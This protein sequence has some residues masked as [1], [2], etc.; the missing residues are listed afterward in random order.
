MHY[1]ADQFDA[2]S[3]LDT[4][5]KGREIL[6]NQYTVFDYD[7]SQPLEYF[8]VTRNNEASS[9]VSISVSNP[10]LLATRK[11]FLRDTLLKYIGVT[12]IQYTLK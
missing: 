10:I 1:S 11:E 3:D 8:E 6:T 2:Y 7:D 9:N 4:W 12:P 5:G